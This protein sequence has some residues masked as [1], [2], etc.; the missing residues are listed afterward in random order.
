MYSLENETLYDKAM[1][2]YAAKLE[3]GAGVV[4]ETVD[5]I[6]VFNEMG[7]EKPG[8]RKPRNTLCKQRRSTIL[9]SYIS[10]M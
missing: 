4:P 7:K 5:Y 3:H 9:P 1:I 10:F 8:I 6:F 2:R